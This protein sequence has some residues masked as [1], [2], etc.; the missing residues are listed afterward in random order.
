MIGNSQPV[1]VP[2]ISLEAS[3]WNNIPP[4]SAAVLADRLGLRATAGIVQANSPQ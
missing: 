2:L 3:G 1:V 4:V